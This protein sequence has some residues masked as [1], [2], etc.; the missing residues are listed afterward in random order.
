M[1]QHVLG[2]LPERNIPKEN[3]E[4]E[5]DETPTPPE[6]ILRFVAPEERVEIDPVKQARHT[7]RYAWGIAPDFPAL[8]DTVANAARNFQP[9][10]HGMIGAALQSRQRSLKTEYLR[11]FGHQ[12]T[13]VHRFRVTTPVIQAIAITATVAI[14]LPDV[15][16]TYDDA[17]KVLAKPGGHRL[18]NS[19]EK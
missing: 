7:L 4:E 13:N 19:A 10:E 8:L 16:V 12:L 1:R 17:R 14:N 11:A 15:D 2:D 6:L 5:N 18:E 3:P 9:S